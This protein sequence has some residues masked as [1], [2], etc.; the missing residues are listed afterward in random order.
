MD[1]TAIENMS[2]EEFI[3]TF[4]EGL[5]VE[6]NLGEMDEGTKEEMKNDLRERFNEFVNRALLESLSEEV[7]DEIDKKVED[8][9]ISEQF[10]IQKINE[11][12][13][14]AAKITLEAME[15]FRETYLEQGA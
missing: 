10:I 7:L 3:D 11:S 2:N 12:G 13:M 9:T 6:K 14:D 1:E 8:D 5:L 15:K 4:L